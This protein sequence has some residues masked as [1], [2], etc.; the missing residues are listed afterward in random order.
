M[1][2]IRIAREVGGEGFVDMID[3]EVEAYIEEHQEVLTNKELE[4]LV[5]SSTEEEEE[6][7]VEPAMWTLE[8]FGKVFRM[9]Q[10]LKEKIMDYD[11]MMKH[12]IKVTCM[13]TEALQPLQEMFN[14]LKRQKQQLPVT[15][16]FHK[17]EKKVSTIEDPQPSASS[18]PDVILQ[19]LFSV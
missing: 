14:E 8:K 3:E 4:D 5:K 17:V 19:S 1:K 11:P 9:A 2:I 15:L 12:S 13:I 16:F 18:A 7:E 10:N 6:T